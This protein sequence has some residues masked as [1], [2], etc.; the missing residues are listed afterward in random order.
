MVT[1]EAEL[2]LP[3]EMCDAAGN[4]NPAA[5]GWSRKPLHGCNLSGRWGRKKRW[6]YWCI[7]NQDMLFSLTLSHLDYLGLAFIYYLDFA[8]GKFME[9]TVT[10]LFGKGCD[11]PEGLGG[12]IQLEDSALCME[13]RDSGND[14]YLRVDSPAFGGEK[15]HAEFQVSR[16]VGHETLNVVIPWSKRL[17]QF[18]SKQNCLPATGKIQIGNRKQEMGLDS[19]ACLDFGRGIWRYA[20]SWNW[21]AFSTRQNGH[22]VGVNMGGKWTDGTDMTENGIC[23]DGRLSKIGE[24]LLFDYDPG[25]FMKPWSIRTPQSEQIRL[26]FTPFFERIAKTDA[27]VLRS[28]VHQMIGRFCG[29]VITDNGEQISIQD[30]IGWAEE[31]QARW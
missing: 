23:L 7:T 5:V 20:S 22:T 18:T 14:I 24:D 16:P 27:L 31:H 26:E 15:L 9:Q 17:Y 19:F 10:R 11:L 6:N 2:K 4:L 28:E 12:L 30:A 1:H 13:M 3:V 21:A 8:S 29:T 25:N